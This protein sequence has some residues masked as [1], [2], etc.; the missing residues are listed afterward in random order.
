MKRILITGANSYVGTNVEKF[1]KNESDKY[2]V[3][4]LDMKNPNWKEFDFSKF[5]VVFHV[6][7]IAHVSTKKS[8]RD[9]YFK[10]NKDLTIE[11]A[12]MA[13]RSNISQFIFMSSM[14]VYSSKETRITQDTIPK[15]DNFYGLSKLEAEKGIM[16]LDDDRF[17]VCVLRPP[18]IYGYETKG[19]FKTL[20]KMSRKLFVFPYF[21]N[22]RS[23]LYI[24]NLSKFVSYYIDNNVNGI[25][26]PQNKEYFSTSQLVVLIRKIYGKSGFY[27][28][29]FNIIIRFLIRFT[30]VFN[31]IFGDYYYDIDSDFD[32]G[33]V[34]L[35]NSIKE[36]LLGVAH[37][38]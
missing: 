2:Y 16:S 28:K 9:L 17:K 27:P 15:P 4:T 20:I 7:G 11:V 5:D 3:E 26:F 14:I 37:D 10:V 22:I 32:F 23:S 38:E 35:E 1:L 36:T 24:H 21:K 18:M 6:A 34:N 29:G 13:K 8:M 33:L 19:N 25:Y 12:K 30:K 31:K